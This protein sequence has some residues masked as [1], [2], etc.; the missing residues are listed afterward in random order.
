M[1]NLLAL[2]HLAIIRLLHMCIDGSVPS[3]PTTTTDDDNVLT[4]KVRLAAAS[5]H[6][7]QSVP[8]AGYRPVHD[9]FYCWCGHCAY[10]AH[11][12]H[13]AP[14]TA[15]HHHAPGQLTRPTETDRDRQTA[16]WLTRLSHHAAALNRI[17]GPQ[18]VS[19][20]ANNK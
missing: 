14:R 6:L 20:S 9:K 4:S 7:H 13:C 19:V 11:C 12:A 10:C 16:C 5:E 17:R 2:L 18:V 3:R 15:A 8:A 1:E